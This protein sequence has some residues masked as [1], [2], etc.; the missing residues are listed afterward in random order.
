MTKIRLNSIPPSYILLGASIT[1]ATTFS[2]W[3][4]SD[5]NIERVNDIIQNYDELYYSGKTEQATA[6]LNGAIESTQN[7]P[8]GAEWIAAVQRVENGYEQLQLYL[9]LVAA[10]PNREAT[11]IEIAE[12]LNSAPESFKSE[13]RDN[14]LIAL[15]RIEGVNENFLTK[16]GLLPVAPAATK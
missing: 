13:Q 16:H 12:L 11:Y 6:L 1:L 8:L 10:T 3:I 2:L 15:S 7:S 9:R 14:Y 5:S 4:Y